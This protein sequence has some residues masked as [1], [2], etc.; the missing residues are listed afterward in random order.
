MDFTTQHDSNIHSYAEKELSFLRINS[1]LPA[2]LHAT[3]INFYNHFQ[4]NPIVP[5]DLSK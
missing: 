4:N 2:K 5:G 3:Y 1:K